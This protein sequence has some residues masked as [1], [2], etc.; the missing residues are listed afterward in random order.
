VVEPTTS[1]WRTTL[2]GDSGCTSTKA[3]GCG[4][5]LAL[6]NINLHPHI[7]AAISLP[8]IGRT[9][10][11]HVPYAP[12]SRLVRSG[13][14]PAPALWNTARMEEACQRTTCWRCRAPQEDGFH[15][16]TE[17]THDPLQLARTRIVA[18]LPDIVSRL[19]AVS[20]NLYLTPIGL[21]QGTCLLAGPAFQQHAQHLRTSIDSGEWSH[22]LTP[23]CKFVLFHLLTVLPWS[24]TLAE[25]WVDRASPHLRTTAVGLGRTFDSIKAAP[26]ALRPLACAWA[27]WAGRHCLHCA[28]QWAGQTASDATAALRNARRRYNAAASRRAPKGHSETEPPADTTTDS[29]ST[30]RSSI[31]HTD[32]SD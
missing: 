3:P 12:L 22:P 11:V 6:T 1:A 2:S 21:P 16:L 30:D 19:G 28:E 23:A 17:C 8:Q 20:P 15:V 4:G 27:H 29:D 5:I 9:G 32:I 13:T 31:T 25:R 7:L 10:L 18:Q 14:N 24:Q 26:Y